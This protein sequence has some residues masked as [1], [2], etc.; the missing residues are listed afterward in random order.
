VTSARFSHHRLTIRGR[1]LAAGRVAL[2]TRTS[3]T[4][5]VRGGA[6]RVTINLRTRPR[7]VMVRFGAT[8]FFRAQTVR[9]R[10]R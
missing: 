3:T 9:V 4:R 7:T 10:V 1:T 8:P 5:R 6:F 2:K